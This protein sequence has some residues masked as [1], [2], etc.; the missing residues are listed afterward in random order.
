MKGDMLAR[1]SLVGVLSYFPC[2]M[3]VLRRMRNV[4]YVQC[5]RWRG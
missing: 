3:Q 2:I 5:P 1:P 4:Q